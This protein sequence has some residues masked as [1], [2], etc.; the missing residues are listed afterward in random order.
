MSTVYFNILS[1][2]KLGKTNIQN[3]K[4]VENSEAAWC[5]ICGDDPSKSQMWKMWNREADL[6]KPPLQDKLLSKPFLSGCRQ[7]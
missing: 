5:P 4:R 1:N 2:V 7:Q 6:S 3:C